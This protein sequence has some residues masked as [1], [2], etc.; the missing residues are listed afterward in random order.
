MKGVNSM[1]IS[2]PWDDSYLNECNGTPNFDH[3]TFL[4][5]PLFSHD[6]TPVSDEQTLI[7]TY[8]K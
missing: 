7:T 8:L 2:A 4:T 1:V 6:W 3:Q 5:K